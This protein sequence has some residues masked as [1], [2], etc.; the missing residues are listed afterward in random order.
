VIDLGGVW[1]FFAL[2]FCQAKMLDVLRGWLLP[3][4]NLYG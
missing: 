1:Q 3:I 4:S 2:D